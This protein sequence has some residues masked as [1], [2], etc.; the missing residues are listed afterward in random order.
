MF[1]AALVFGLVWGVYS[2]ASDVVTSF[3]H[4][5]DSRQAAIEKAMEY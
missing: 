4:I 5:N 2:G 1:K 3:K